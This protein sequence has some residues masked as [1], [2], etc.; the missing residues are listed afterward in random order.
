VLDEVLE[1]EKLAALDRIQDPELRAGLLSKARGQ[2]IDDS[3]RAQLVDSAL[4]GDYKTALG[5]GL[6]KVNFDNK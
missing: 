2:L 3:S 4:S 5:I 1:A 6:K